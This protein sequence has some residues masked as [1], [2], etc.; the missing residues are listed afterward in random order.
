MG[1][2][3]KARAGGLGL[4]TVPARPRSAGTADPTNSVLDIPDEVGCESLSGI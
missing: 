4:V 1:G 3:L 2:K